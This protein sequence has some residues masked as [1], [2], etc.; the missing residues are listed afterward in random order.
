MAIGV[1]ALVAIAMAAW[2]LYER[3]QKNKLLAGAGM[4]KQEANQQ[5]HQHP[6]QPYYD[7]A[8]G[9]KTPAPD[10]QSPHRQPVPEMGSYENRRSNAHEM[11]S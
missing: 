2:A 4:H 8:Y 5:H 11:Q 9:S 7:Q 6:Q 1:V 10:Y 3:R